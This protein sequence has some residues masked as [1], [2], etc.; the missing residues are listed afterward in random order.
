MGVNAQTTVP[1]FTVGQILTSAQQNTGARTG[2]PVFATTVTRDA[3]FGGAN[4]ALAE[5][6]LCYLEASNV[7]QYYDG[8]AWATVG[9]STASGLTLISATT[10]GTTVSSVTVSSAFSSTYDNYKIV[11]SGGTSSAVVTIGLQLGAT[12]TGYYGSFVRYDYGGTSSIAT[13]NNAAAFTRFGFGNTNGLIGV[14]DL[15]TPNLATNTFLA[16]GLAYS[17]TTNGAG[18]YHAYLDN[19][20]QYTAF[21]LTPSGGTLTG[22]TIRVYGYS[23]S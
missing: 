18:A 1:T 13:D 11:L 22:G 16:G 23:N 14:S 10:I 21:T 7:V 15:F 2:V 8:A 20:T 12:T 9:P 5:G 4:K 19:T 17:A 3:A 6:Q